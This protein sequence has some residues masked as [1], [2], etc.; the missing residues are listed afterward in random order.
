MAGGRSAGNLGTGRDLG[1]LTGNRHSLPEV[2]VSTELTMAIDDRRHH[3][4][5]TDCRFQP[6]ASDL[7]LFRPGNLGYIHT[8]HS[9]YNHNFGL[10]RP[11]YLP[12]V[13][14]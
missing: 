3:D 12:L 4:I 7:G 1:Q 9:E 6:V 10:R 11:R 8:S 13:S 5:R 2:S 14:G